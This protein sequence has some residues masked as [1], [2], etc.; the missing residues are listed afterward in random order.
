M[1]PMLG[2]LGLK[3]NRVGILFSCA[4]NVSIR[5]QR[6]VEWIFSVIKKGEANPDES[7]RAQ[8]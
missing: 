8:L 6:L 5:P 3:F 1:N 2:E 7:Q 4:W